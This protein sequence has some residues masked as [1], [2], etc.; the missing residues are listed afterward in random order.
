MK[1]NIIVKFKEDVVLDDILEDIKSI[2]N[3]TLTIEGIHQVDYLVNCIDRSN[4]YHLCIQITMDKEALSTYDGCI[5][6][7]TWKQKYGPLIESKAI[8]DYE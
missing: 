8:F 7:N 3:E 6:H 5:P 2:F 1:H 4:R